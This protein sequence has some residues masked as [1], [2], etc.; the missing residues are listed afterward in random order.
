MATLIGL[1]TI[2]AFLYSAVITIFGGWTKA[3]GITRQ[4]FFEAVVFIISFFYLEQYFEAIAKRK[5]KRL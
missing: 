4:F 5:Q 2:A 1:G 3:L